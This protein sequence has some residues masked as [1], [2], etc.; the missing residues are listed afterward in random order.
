MYT[1]IP[2]REPSQ[3]TQIR[4]ALLAQIDQDLGEHGRLPAER[5]L[6]EQFATT[7]ITLREALLQLEA[8]GVLYREER[9]GWFVAPPRLAYNPSARGYFDR[10]VRSQGRVP[11]TRLLQVETQAAT[12][13]IAALLQIRPLDPVYLVRRARSV[14]GRRVLFVEH[15]L[16]AACF[17][18]FERFGE[19]TLSHSLT[20]LYRQHYDIEYGRVRFEIMPTALPEMA[21]RVLKVAPGSPAL[22]VQ[23]V[24]A[25]QH[26]RWIDCDLEYWRQDAVK[27]CIEA[28]V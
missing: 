17:P 14:D 27:V 18:D 9:R 24:N 11:G 15:Y 21:A 28:G 6:S 2:G 12:E 16:N 26:G 13:Q 22:Q 19:R 8:E 23:R 20:E 4:Q 25:D 5:V 1:G 7:R 3:V 10:M